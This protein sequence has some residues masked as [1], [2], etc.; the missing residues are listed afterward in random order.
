MS[1]SRSNDGIHGIPPVA[2]APTDR[3]S[4]A[5]TTLR[6]WRPFSLRLRLGYPMASS[7]YNELVDYELADEVSQPSEL[8]SATERTPATT[9]QGSGEPVLNA[10]NTH[11]S[12]STATSRIPD[13]TDSPRSPMVTRSQSRA[14]TPT[15][16]TRSDQ[17]TSPTQVPI[18]PPE[19]PGARTSMSG[20]AATEIDRS[21]QVTVASLNKLFPAP[22]DYDDLD[23]QSSDRTTLKIVGQA[24]WFHKPAIQAADNR[25]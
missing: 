15:A 23:I 6:V 21:A 24:L 22:Q 20:E 2:S 1:C 9:V 25:P 17:P 4:F 11:V 18:S 3:Y 5:L 12:F 19:S 13:T 7:D 16:A 14:N 8:V 10:P